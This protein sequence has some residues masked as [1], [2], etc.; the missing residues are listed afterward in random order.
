M[1][2]TLGTTIHHSTGPGTGNIAYAVRNYEGSHITVVPS[3]SSY[4]YAAFTGKK[5]I[6]GKETVGK[7]NIL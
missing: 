2:G 4:I 7:K 5:K 3:F 6:V 1:P